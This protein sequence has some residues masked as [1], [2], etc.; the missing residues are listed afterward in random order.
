MKKIHAGVAIVALV[1]GLLAGASLMALV[2]VGGD[3]P[4]VIAAETESNGDEAT[5]RDRR[6]EWRERRGERGEHRAEKWQGLHDAHGG[7]DHRCAFIQRWNEH[8]DALLEDFAA[9]LGVTPDEVVAA[10]M[11]VAE[12]R[13]SE[14]VEEGR[15]SQEKADRILAAIEDPGALCSE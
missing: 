10:A 11:S 6:E 5:D 1:V 12:S 13:L 15:L 8:R 3:D 4:V 14:A 9:E 2:D 7:G